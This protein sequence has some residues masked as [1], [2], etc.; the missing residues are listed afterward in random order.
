MDITLYISRFLYRIRYQLIF[1]SI[2]VTALVAYFTQFMT[3]T[4]TVNTSIYTGI[5]SSTGLDS[6][7]KPDWMSLN[8]SFDN[9]INLTKAKGTLENVSL[10]LL[11]LN[12][13]QGDP[14]NDNRYITAKRYKELQKILPE[15]VAKLIDKN[16]L[17]KTIKNL[18]NYKQADPDNF[19]F[20][21]F[22]R[23]HPN[24]SYNALKD[25][26]VKRLGN[27]DLIEISFKSNDP[28]IAMNTVK[29][30]NEKLIESYDS[31]KYKAAN[32]VIT[33]YEEQLKKLR[34][35]LD[36]LE[37]DLTNY[38]VEN[39]VINYGEQTKAIAVAF[40]A[41]E[42]RY[43]QTSK[44]YES[45]KKLVEE[46]ERQM[47]TRTK[48]FKTNSEFINALN[49]ISTINGKITE[50]EM[51]STESP[52]TSNNEL[53]HYK[54]D[55]KN[56]EK[57]IGEL[58]TDMNAYK[59]S[60]EGVAI[61]DMVN[62]WLNEMIRNTK[63]K[64]ELKVLDERRK[65]F[66][67]QYKLYSPIGTQINRMEREINV[68]E[69]SYL[70]VLHALNLAMLKQKNIQLTSATLN[71]IT[72]PTFPLA[73]DGSKR[74][75]FTIAAFFGS[76]IFITGC[77]LVI[78]LLDRTLRDAER[79]RRLTDVS[80]LG[81]FTGHSQL[82]YRGYTKACNRISAAYACSRLNSYLTP[83][84]TICIN[85]LSIEEGEGKSFVSSYLI[86]QWK[87]QGLTVKYLRA[88][89]DFLIDHAYL[90]STGFDRFRLIEE[91]E[92]PDILLIEHL[93]VQKNS[94]SLDMIKKADVNLLITN[95][96]RVWKYSDNEFIA[97]LKEIGGTSPLFIYLNNATR[98]AVEDFT[99]Q[100]PPQS[101][102]RTFANRMMYMGLTARDAAVKQSK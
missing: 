81:A 63:A 60:K 1:G 58:S 70:E 85:V 8:N 36:Y 53:E 44:E 30:I 87:E 96:C 82:K 91:K 46:L 66:S 65:S 45:S 48:L 26:S 24:Y 56:A 77:N 68:T 97:Y 59:Y 51:F 6:E 29:L 74:M 102:M 92:S 9:L 28:G 89:R 5:A 54:Q 62:Q 72:P 52:Q 10:N 43:E 99:G 47:E 37:N 101:S 25:V 42:D 41:Y 22:N 75:L 14:D 19:L 71:T 2:I 3:K 33:Y 23:V 86:E 61:E 49:E 69:Q 55:L 21:L 12:L 83:G 31:L 50:I 4:Y 76:L 93:S 20:E 88:E 100:L 90:F 13:V 32:D 84:K 7:D 15:D 40:T 64:A 67:D 16:S 79:T 39:G 17:E 38:N 94:L 18:N 11:A 57:K 27:S 80:V 95:A 34:T 35:K 73:S 78:E 98:E